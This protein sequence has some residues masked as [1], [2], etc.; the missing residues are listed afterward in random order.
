MTSGA[1]IL[2]DLNR[3]PTSVI[4][5]WLAAMNP[6]TR[7]RAASFLSPR[8][9]RQFVTARYLL[10]TLLMDWTGLTPN[11][12]ESSSL[13]PQVTNP[14]IHCSISHSGNAVMAGF[15][16]E[17]A[18]GVDIEFHRQRDVERLVM[19]Y[20]HPDEQEVFAKLNESEKQYW[21]YQIWTRKEAYAKLSRHGLTLKQLS[22]SVLQASKMETVNTYCAGEYTASIVHQSGVPVTAQ[23]ISEWNSDPSH[24]RSLCPL[25]LTS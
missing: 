11:I 23:L 19:T 4:D 2:A 17:A 12:V 6:S 5:N 14:D 9:Y 1:V 21:F 15:S 3:V 24:W 7:N 20:F 13:G 8:R 16:T 22:R 10:A 25:S 18:I